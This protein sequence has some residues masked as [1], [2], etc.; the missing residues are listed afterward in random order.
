MFTHSH[1]L[2]SDE[3]NEI[4]EDHVTSLV[5]MI[6]ESAAPSSV[7]PFLLHR[8]AQNFVWYASKFNKAQRIEH[9]LRRF[10]PPV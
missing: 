2:P 8:H 6:Q 9:F 5:S 3:N 10:S 4:N 1:A 7:S